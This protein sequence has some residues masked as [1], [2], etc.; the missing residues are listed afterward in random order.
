MGILQHLLG[1]NHAHGHHHDGHHHDGHNH[2]GQSPIPHGQSHEPAQ[3]GAIHRPAAYERVNRL[4]FLGRRDRVY[5]GLAA[6]STAR[7]GDRALDIG[8]GSGALTRALAL[9]VGPSGSVVAID[10]APEM[11]AWCRQQPGDP[12]AASIR[13]AVSAAESLDLP[14]GSVD[15]VAS[16]LVVHHIDPGARPAALAQIARVLRPGGS[17]LL[18]DIDPPS[19]R[20]VRGLIRAL[21]GPEMAGR[22]SGELAALATAAGLRIEGQG[23]RGL[24]GYVRAVRP[25]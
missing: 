11:I 18:V 24:L 9:R 8:C 13:Y 15:V 12:A 17:V 22:D 21:T 20:L 23:R 7:P 6:L 2:D 1:H 16:A 14:D 19:S 25:A 3:A 10:P 4:L 5:T